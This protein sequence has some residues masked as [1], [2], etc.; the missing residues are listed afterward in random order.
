MQSRK[1]IKI[2]SLFILSSLV[3][4]LSGCSNISEE[5]SALIS[6]NV[7]ESV[8]ENIIPN[9]NLASDAENIQSGSEITESESDT[10]S[11]ASETNNVVNSQ[12]SSKIESSNQSTAT[13]SQCSHPKFWGDGILV[14]YDWH[15]RLPGVENRYTLTPNTCTENRKVVYKCPVCSEPVLYEEIEPLGHNFSGE[16]ELLTYPSGK[17]DG[18]YGYR[19]QNNSCSE[20]QISRTIPKLTGDYSG[21]D[22][23]FS[24]LSGTEKEDIYKIEYYLTIFDERTGGSIPTIRYDVNALR[25]EIELINANGELV[26][27]SI[28]LEQDKLD[29]GW[30]Y[31]G[32]IRDNSYYV[33]YCKLA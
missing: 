9:E 2:I 6:S 14:I 28:Y 5:D 4:S 29:D 3:C 25:G 24:I 31:R 27:Y 30:H 22:S 15:D 17:S 10:S 32:F 13:K 7:L 11:I 12:T 1:A 20:T 26:K 16:E 8:S 21:I 19:C 18:S 23:C 33:D